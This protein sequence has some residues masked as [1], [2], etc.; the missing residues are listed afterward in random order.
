[1]RLKAMILK[2]EVKKNIG[3]DPRTGSPDPSYF[4]EATVLDI[5]TSAIYPCSRADKCREAITSLA[6]DC[7]LRGTAIATT[8][9]EGISVAGKGWWLSIHLT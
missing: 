2:V 9:G 8:F 3:Y 5:E 1:M 4:L 6:F 7:I